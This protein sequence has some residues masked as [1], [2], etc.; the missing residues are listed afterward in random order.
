MKIVR[1]IIF[2]SL[3]ILIVLAPAMVR[4][5]KAKSISI[6][7]AIESV[8]V[9]RDRA[10]VKRVFKQDHQPGNYIFKIANLPLL[11]LDES[12]RVSGS[13]S[14]AA[15]ILDIKIK[16]A[17]L[18]ESAIGRIGELEKDQREM[19]KQVRVLTD[20]MDLLNRKDEFLRTLLSDKGGESDKKQEL[21]KKGIAEWSRMF[22]FLESS[23]EKIYSEKR[24]LEEEK[25]K[26]LDKKAVID[27]ELGQQIEMR[28]K[29][30]KSIEIEVEVGRGGSL[31]IEVSYIVPQVSWT[32]VYDLRFSSEKREAGL[33]CQALVRQETGEDWE[34]T[35]LTLSTA[36]PMTENT[37]PELNPLI[38]DRP[39]SLSMAGSNIIYG[40]VVLEDG[41]S[42]P[43]VS[44]TLLYG[45]YKI[46]DSVTSE[47]GEFT[48]SDL[49]PGTYQLRSQLEGFKTSIQPN[50]QLTLGQNIR[51]TIPLK[52]GTIN[53]AITVAGQAP[54]IDTK[55]SDRSFSFNPNQPAVS[56]GGRSGKKGS[57]VDV[58]EKPII[59][60]M[61][62]PT[63][64][65]SSQAVAV[66]FSLK[67]KET[68]LSN[69]A[70]QK[71]TM[72]VEAIPFQREYQAIPKIMEQ[73]FLRATATNTAFFPLLAGKVS[74]FYDES[75]VSST[76]IPQVSANE[77]FT[78]AI[79]EGSGIK[80]K[81]ELVEKKADGT[82]LFSKKLQTVFEY[83]ITVEN[84]QK[85]NESITVVDQIPVSE[86]KE[87]SIEL[88]SASPSPLKPDEEYAEKEKKEGVLKWLLQLKPLEK[89]TIDFKYSVT[90]P[91]KLDV[92]N[93]D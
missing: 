12:V 43:G 48:F 28:V 16:S 19:E 52:L 59:Q 65:I 56:S 32:P 36:R 84:F 13:G 68:V 74:I 38:L 10:L 70:P 14:A 21:Q 80:V 2:L 89:K 77:K 17:R 30:R 35:S 44:V 87:I 46:K 91:R 25:A 60:K 1:N 39:Q 53:E 92:Y 78:V 31:Q 11:L 34:N 88:I 40:K 54:M 86:N 6:A 3:F 75:F 24:S 41:T 47:N 83:R 58:I 23:L 5:E 64:G 85:S 76:I 4:G 29:E 69:N 63:A 72:A 18:E 62:V 7:S 55:S 66:T 82:G 93:L 57:D 90:R 8:T 81:R 33:S 50:I 37:L 27:H 42:V 22:D 67:Q 49:A 79:G 61:E 71:V 45:R 73:C 15:K 20:R 51:I 26:L 9:Y